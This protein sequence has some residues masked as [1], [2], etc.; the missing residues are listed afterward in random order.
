MSDRYRWQRRK[1]VG[2]LG[3]YQCGRNSR[4]VAVADDRVGCASLT[5]TADTVI[6]DMAAF[7]AIS[8]GRPTTTVVSYRIEAGLK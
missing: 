6:A 2:V 4:I 8:I 1:I 3:M 7:V 5:G